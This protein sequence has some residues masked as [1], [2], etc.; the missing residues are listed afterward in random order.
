MFWLQPGWV[1]Y[2][3]EWILSFPR[4]PLGSVSIQIWAIACGT[5]VRLVG[6]A[7]VAGWGLVLERRESRENESEKVK[8]GVRASERGGREEKKEL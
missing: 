4:A 1:P 3:V 6:A 7:V 8:I 5:V 2:W